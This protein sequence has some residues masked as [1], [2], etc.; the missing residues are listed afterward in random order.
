MAIRP[1]SASSAPGRW[2]SGSRRPRP[3]RASRRSWP[4][5]RRGPST[6]RAARSRKQL[7]KEVE[8][9]KLSAA[10]HGSLLERL[11]WTA[12]LHDL[13]NAD[14]VIESIVE[15]LPIKREHFSRLDDVVKDDAIFATNTSTLTVGD[16]ASAAAVGHGGAAGG[17]R[18]PP[19]KGGRARRSARHRRRLRHRCESPWTSSSR[20]QPEEDF[21]SQQRKDWCAVAASQ[22]A[23]AILGLA[24]TRRRRSAPIADRIGEWESRRDSKN[25]G[26]GPAAIAQ[27]LAAY[28]ATGYEVRAYERRPMPSSTPPRRSAP[29]GT[30]VILIAWRGAHTWVMT[31]YRA[32]ADPLRLRRCAR[33]RHLHLRSLVSADLEHLGRIGPARHVPGHAARC[34]ATT[35]VWQRPEGRYPDRDGKFLV[36][37][38]TTAEGGVP[39]RRSSPTGRL[40]PAPPGGQSRARPDHDRQPPS[41]AT[42]AAMP[43]AKA[44]GRATRPAGSASR[45]AEDDHG[46]QP[47]ER[48]DDRQDRVVGRVDGPRQQV[49]RALQGHRDGEGDEEQ[50]RPLRHPPRRRPRHRAGVGSHSSATR[51]RP[52]AAST[53]RTAIMTRLVRTRPA[54]RAR[55]P[56]AYVAERT[57]NAATEKATPMRLTGTLWKLRAKLTELTLPG[58]ERRS[59]GREVQEDERLDGLADGAGDRRAGRTRRT[60]D[61]GCPA[62]A[63]SG[64]R[65]AGCPGCAR[66]GA[67]A[68]R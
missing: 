44:S 63:G 36:V 31:G 33:H 9:G 5:P 46:G 32:D 18:A 62:S 43:A 59:D 35:C 53:V 6:P 68:R 11:H 67:G 39:A 51:A 20:P 42:L 22:I 65:C 29:T 38:P 4:R 13:A 66:S 24:T 50:R 64:S 45:F 14:L 1:P 19:G 49:G 28:G 7:Q 21:I 52:S 30:P 26:W 8:R 47:D 16:L 58:H 23:L 25:G 37:V 40:R 61:C 15:E 27:A 54:K 34:V 12:H 55:S 57:G 56:A 17:P 3:G 41:T 2:V 48:G 60:R 10:D